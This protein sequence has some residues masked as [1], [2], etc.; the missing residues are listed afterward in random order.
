MHRSR[1]VAFF[2]SKRSSRHVIGTIYGAADHI[3]RVL[4]RFWGTKDHNDLVLKRSE[5]SK[6]KANRDRC[7]LGSRGSFQLDVD[8]AFRL[9]ARDEVARIWNAG[10]SSR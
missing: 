5:E 8:A 4:E 3:D 6:T 2:G 7:L 10:R 9:R 1:V